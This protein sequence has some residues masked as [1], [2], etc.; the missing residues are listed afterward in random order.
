MG[1]ASYQFQSWSDGGAQSHD[2]IADATATYVATFVGPPPAPPTLTASVMSSSITALNWSDV[3]GETGYRVERALAGGSFAQI[4]TAGVNATAF[5]DSGLSAATTYQYRV[6][7][8]NTSGESAPSNVASARTLPAVIR[9]NFQPAGSSVPSGYLVDS[10][11]AFGSRGKGFSYGWN[12][13]NNHTRDR[14]ST[15]SPDQRYDTLNHM[16]KGGSFSWQLAVPNGTYTVRIVAGDPGH[17]D[18]T[19]RINVEGVLA[20]NGRPTSAARWIDRTV[21]VTVAD[22]QLTI[23]NATGAANNKICFI[24]ITTP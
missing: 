7:A 6:R 10:G 3:A 2:V 16:Q 11:A 23:S 15:R 13:T 1:G 20:I 22:G 24:D 14:N 17:I 8:F 18:S 19:Y 9:I 5:T 12:A 21:T 4:G